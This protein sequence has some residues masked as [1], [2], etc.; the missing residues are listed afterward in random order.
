[1]VTAWSDVPPF[2]LTVPKLRL[3][4]SAEM[5]VAPFAPA[6]ALGDDPRLSVGDGLP[7]PVV[8]PPVVEVVPSVPVELLTPGV[9]FCD[10]VFVFVCLPPTP[11]SRRISTP[12]PVT[13][14]ATPE[15]TPGTVVQKL[16]FPSGMRHLLSHLISSV[17]YGGSLG[18]GS[19]PSGRAVC[20][21]RPGRVKANQGYLPR[22]AGIYAAGSGSARVPGTEELFAPPRGR[23][24]RLGAWRAPT[25]D[26]LPTSDQGRCMGSISSP[27]PTR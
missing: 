1:M 8:P 2:T 18:A 4:G 14:A 15:M 17:L 3:G 9:G 13:M 22:T 23:R 16:L 7:V 27:S 10:A 25:R 26:S 5:P 19:G 6:L 21:Q 24:R 11:S 12:R 20:S